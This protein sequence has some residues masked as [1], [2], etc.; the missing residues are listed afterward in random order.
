MIKPS[1]F[2]PQGWSLFQKIKKKS[3]KKLQVARAKVMAN[4]RAG[5]AGLVREH[6]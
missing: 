4:R 6:K 2:G 3:G 1:I 5:P